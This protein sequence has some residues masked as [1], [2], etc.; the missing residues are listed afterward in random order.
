VRKLF[1]KWNALR[2]LKKKINTQKIIQMGKIHIH[3]HGVGKFVLL[4]ELEGDEEL[5][6]VS[7]P[8]ME[9]HADIIDDFGYQTGKQF[10]CLGGGRMDIKDNNIRCYGYSI[11]FGAPNPETVEQILKQNTDKKIIMEIGVGY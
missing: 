1:M 9:Y 7:N 6:I 4:K 2:I 11:G 8:Y 10:S 5:Y 3:T